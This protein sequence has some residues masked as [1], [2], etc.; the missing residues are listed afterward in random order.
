MLDNAAEQGVTLDTELRSVKIDDGRPW[1]VFKVKVSVKGVWKN[2]AL[3]LEHRQFEPK[4]AG[5]HNAASVRDAK[6]RAEMLRLRK[7]TDGHLVSPFLAGVFGGRSPAIDGHVAFYQICVTDGHVAL[8]LVFQREF[9]PDWET[10]RLI[11]DR[12]RCFLLFIMTAVTEILDA[13]FRFIHVHPSMLGVD[14]KRGHVQLMHLGFGTMVE[15]KV[16]QCNRGQ[17][18]PIVK[19]AL[20]RRNTSTCA[21]KGFE[22]SKYA[23]LARYKRLHAA[24]GHGGPPRPTRPVVTQRA[25]KASR[26]AA[27][28][29]RK[30]A[31]TDAVGSLQPKKRARVAN[32]STDSLAAAEMGIDAD[33]LRCEGAVKFTAADVASSLA[34][35][36]Q[37]GLGLIVLD[38]S[39][40]FFV[41]EKLQPIPPGRGTAAQERPDADRLRLSDLHQTAAMVWHF[42]QRREGWKEDLKKVLEGSPS[43]DDALIDRLVGLLDPGNESRQPKAIRRLAESLAG[44]FHSTSRGQDVEHPQ[45]SDFFSLPALDPV[46]ETKAARDGISMELKLYPLAGDPEFVKKANKAFAC[47]ELRGTVL[48]AEPGDAPPGGP[49]DALL[50]DEP[51]KGNGVKASQRMKRNSF[52]MWYVGNKPESE[53]SG[54]Y[55]VS[56]KLA[57]KTHG[58]RYSDGAPGLDL[59]VN[60]I[61]GYGA[62]G[63]FVNSAKSE[64]VA[65]LKLLPYQAF[66]HKGKI[67]IPMAVKDRDIE[68]GDFFSWKYDHTA[69]NGRSRPT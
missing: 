59:T 34:G 40:S 27:T 20:M 62:P 52:G 5:D 51:D 38:E 8:D 65:N 48:P 60:D 43:L 21:S 12:C 57:N 17:K 45:D 55:V 31:A 63:C 36:G 68:A 23:N 14:M 19:E 54:R 15:P 1:I 29:R 28:P 58:L 3:T 4:R 47:N 69:L 6:L 25:T 41:D 32:P 10:Q 16:A 66:E 50:I 46:Q 37:E 49:R 18:K 13:G 61:L 9:T 11:T 33:V 26:T 2:A 39:E 7:R 56:L 35:S 67:W 53:P 24:L 42:F 64:A 22:P 30:R 44:I